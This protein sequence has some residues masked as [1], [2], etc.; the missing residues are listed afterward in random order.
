MHVTDAY[1]A[2]T[3]QGKRRALRGIAALLTAEKLNTNQDEV[4]AIVTGGTVLARLSNSDVARTISG[5]FRGQIGMDVGPDEVLS[6]NS[7]AGE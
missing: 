2:L 3:E 7:N 5:Y 4:R 1:K 6:R